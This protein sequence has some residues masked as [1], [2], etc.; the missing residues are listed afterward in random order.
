MKTA[1]VKPETGLARAEFNFAG[2]PLRVHAYNGGHRRADDGQH[3]HIDAACS[4][5]DIGDDLFI[6]A[7]NRIDITQRGAEKR[8][9]APAPA[10]LV[11]KNIV[12]GA[13]GRI[14]DRRHAVQIEQHRA[15]AGIIAC[16]R[17]EI[18]AELSHLFPL[19]L[20]GKLRNVR[21]VGRRCNR[22]AQN[23]H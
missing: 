14:V 22:A 7:E 18:D 4:L 13:A 17:R 20:H 11:I 15:Y 8:P 6:V 10:R 9:H 23:F 19:P 12:A 21:P 16:K 1:A 2:N 3:F 5:A